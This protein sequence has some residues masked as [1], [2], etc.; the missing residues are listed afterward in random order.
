MIICGIYFCLEKNTH[1]Y[2]KFLLI[3]NGRNKKTVVTA[4][5]A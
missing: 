4:Q 3:L 1:L 2:T 5:I